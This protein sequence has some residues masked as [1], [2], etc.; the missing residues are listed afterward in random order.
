MIDS[1]NKATDWSYPQNEQIAAYVN[2][3]SDS[4][5]QVPFSIST[6]QM[7]IRILFQS[8]KKCNGENYSQELV[9]STGCFKIPNS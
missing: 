9:A 1:Y 7:K 3:R 2:G 6:L 5:K 4:P 8:L